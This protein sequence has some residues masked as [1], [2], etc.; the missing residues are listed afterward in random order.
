MSVSYGSTNFSCC[1]SSLSYRRCAASDVPYSG[2]LLPAQPHLTNCL[3]DGNRK[4]STHSG[5]VVDDER[6]VLVPVGV[7]AVQFRCGRCRWRECDGR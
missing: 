7:H 4:R 3:S 6:E 1:E 2:K 5:T